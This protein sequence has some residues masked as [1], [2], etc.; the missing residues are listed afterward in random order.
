MK[1]SNS[2]KPLG[3]KTS[4]GIYAIFACALYVTHYILVPRYT[5]STGKPYLIGYLWGWT[6]TVGLVFLASLALYGMEGHPITWRSFAARF[7]LDHMPPPDWLWALAVIVA[8][9]GFMFG[10]SFTSKWLAAIPFFAPHPMF[11]PEL[12][13][14]AVMNLS[15]GQFM[16]M[17]LKGQ[18]WIVAA[19][20]IGWLLNIF[21]EEFF[22]RGWML[23]RQEA[24][25]GKYAW[26]VNGTM[27]CFQHFMQPWNFLAIW[28]GALFMAFVVQSRRNT[29]IG[30]IQHGLMNF[31]AFVFILQG[32]IG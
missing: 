7:R 25:F 23:P 32:V 29:W 2:L 18:W 20:F 30:V 31:A 12:R 9:S 19:Y 1:N 11:P 4:L 13:P 15:R 21:G 3:W 10:L 26:A 24:A 22:Y 17:M 14:D 5:E 28:P 27:F 6:L 16:G 8:A